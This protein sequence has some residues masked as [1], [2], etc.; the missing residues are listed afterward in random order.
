[1]LYSLAIINFQVILGKENP[2]IDNRKDPNIEI[3]KYNLYNSD[4]SCGDYG[5]NTHSTL[6]IDEMSYQDFIKFN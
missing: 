3:K 6:K 1:M 2:C 4:Y 5:I